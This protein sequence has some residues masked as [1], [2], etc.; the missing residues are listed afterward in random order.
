MVDTPLSRAVC[1]IIMKA[2]AETIIAHTALDELL[3]LTFKTHR[4]VEQYNWSVN[5]SHNLL[6]KL[7]ASN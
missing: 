6:V 5:I 7:N 4:G 2:S 1:D 3:F